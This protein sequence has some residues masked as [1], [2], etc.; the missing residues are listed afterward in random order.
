M[1]YDENSKR[2]I[3]LKVM[4]PRHGLETFETKHSESS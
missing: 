1:F 4:I 2:Y 3:S